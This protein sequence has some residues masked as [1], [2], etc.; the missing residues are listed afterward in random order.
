MLP[1]HPALWAPHQP[2]SPPPRAGWLVTVA[3][4]ERL[5]ARGAAVLTF[6]PDK[7][8]IS[9]MGLNI[10]DVSKRPKVSD[11]AYDWALRLLDTKKAV[12][13]LNQLKIQ[14]T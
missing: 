12:P 13:V 2:A 9:A 4:Q 8:T 1:A 10:M 5:K 11:L 3:E 14:I 7:K 6:H